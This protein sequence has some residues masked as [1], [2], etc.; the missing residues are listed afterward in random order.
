MKLQVVQID[1]W[2]DPD[3]GWTYNNSIPL[4]D[5]EING[6]LTARKVFRALRGKGFL[7]KESDYRL[8]DCFSFEGI[9]VVKLK[10]DDMPLFDLIE[11]V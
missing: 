5:I 2:A 3:G 8:D 11:Q 10:E 6:E 4:T 9:W 1:A 7:R